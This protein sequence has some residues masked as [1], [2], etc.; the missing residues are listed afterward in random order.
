MF[1][2]AVLSVMVALALDVVMAVAA[3]FW[4]GKFMGGSSEGVNSMAMQQGGLGLILTMLIISAPPMAA[5]FFQ[6]VLAN[7]NPY[8]SFNSPA[9]Y[10]TGPAMNNN[11]Q[12]QPYPPG[13]PAYG[14]RAPTQTTAIEGQGNTARPQQGP[15][16]QPYLGAGQT[17]TVTNNEIRTA[18][19]ARLG[20]AQGGSTIATGPSN[21]GGAGT[22]NNVVIPPPNLP[23]KPPGGTG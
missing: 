5:S 11:Q 22:P 10:S 20:S 4:V 6:G 8:S 1:S 13:H 9:G 12:A 15:V 2:L 3:S 23:P 17:S 16:N 14:G 21:T 7:F 19:D 18:Q